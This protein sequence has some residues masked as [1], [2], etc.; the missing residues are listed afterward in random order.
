[1]TVEE[2]RDLVRAAEPLSAA[3]AALDGSEPL[4]YRALLFRFLERVVSARNSLVLGQAVPPEL[5]LELRFVAEALPDMRTRTR[6]AAQ[7]EPP[8][9]GE[10]GGAVG[11]RR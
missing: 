7:A 9:S 6:E 5:E 3:S 11:P 1:M 4:A 8:G 10:P 2:L